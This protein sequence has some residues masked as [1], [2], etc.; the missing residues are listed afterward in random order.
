MPRN[1]GAN[2]SSNFLIVSWNVRSINARMNDLYSLISDFCPHIICMSEIMLDPSDIIKVNNYRAVI[3]PRNRR[4]GG[5]AI[6][7]RSDVSV[8]QVFMQDVFDLCRANEV[9]LVTVSCRVLGCT[10]F[11]ISSLYSP[12]RS[13]GGGTDLQ[14]WDSLFSSLYHRGRGL[15]T[16]DFNGHSGLWSLEGSRVNEEGRKIESAVTNA[17]YT[18]MN[19]GSPTWSSADSSSRSVLDL[20]FVCDSVATGFNFGVMPYNY[21]SD[22]FPIYLETDS[23]TPVVLPIRPTIK[24]K[25]VDWVLCN[26]VMQDKVCDLDFR[27]Q[28]GGRLYDGFVEAARGSLLVS[29]GRLLNRVKCNPHRRASPWWNENCMSLMKSKRD[30]YSEFATHPSLENFRN[31]QSVRNYIKKEIKKIRIDSFKKFCESLNMNTDTGKVWRT[32]RSFRDGKVSRPKLP[33]NTDRDNTLDLFHDLCRPNIIGSAG[34]GSPPAPGPSRLHSGYADL[35][36][37]LGSGYYPLPSG[38]GEASDGGDVGPSIGSVTS[39]VARANSVI[40][41]SLTEG[42]IRCSIRSI[43]ARS[44]HGPDLVGPDFVK[45][46]SPWMVE[47]LLRIFN[48]IFNHGSFP[49][50]WSNYF[51]IFIPKPGTNKFRPIALANTLFKVFEKIIFYRLN[52][53]CERV[54]V[55]PDFQLG[56]RRGRSVDDS[57]SVLSS[58]I[59]LAFKRGI[60]LGALFLDIKGA[61]DNV[62]PEI[63]RDI[64]GQVGLSP[65]L[66]RFIY[67]VTANRH[68]SGYM[69]GE[70][71]GEGTA[72]RGL[73]QGSSLSPL[74]Y[75]IY[76]AF[77]ARDLPDE[78]KVLYYADDI[79]VFVNSGSLRIIFDRLQEAFVHFHFV[80]KELQLELSCSKSKICIFGDRGRI[81]DRSCI[82]RNGLGVSFLGERVPVVESVCFLGVVFDRRLSWI[83]HAKSVGLRCGRRVNVMKSVAG[84]RWGAHPVTLLTIYRGWVRSLLDYGCV[85]FCDVGGDAACLMDRV[86]FRSLRIALSLFVTTPT[87]VI[88]HLAGEMPLSVRRRLLVS[89]RLIKLLGSSFDV[90]LIGRFISSPSYRRFIEDMKTD[91]FLLSAIEDLRNDFGQ[92][93][94][95]SGCS[96]FG[97]VS[98]FSSFFSIKIDIDSG[99]QIP[100]RGSGTGGAEREGVRMVDGDGILCGIL[101]RDGLSD[102]CIFYTDG[103]HMPNVGV[104]AGVFGCAGAIRLR[105]GLCKFLSIF[106]AEA[107]AILHALRNIEEGGMRKSVIISDSLSVLSSLKSFN[108]P[109]RSHPLIAAIKEI[110][111]SLY[112]NG[113]DVRLMWVPSHSGLLGNDEADAMARAGA[114]GEDLTFEHAKFCFPSNLFPVIQEEFIKFTLD[115]FR[116]EAIDKGFRYFN[117]V[118]F[119]KLEPWFQD[120]PGLSRSTITFLSRLRSHHV[121]LAYHLHEKGLKD[122]PRCICGAIETIQHF[123]VCPER[124]DHLLWLETELAKIDPSFRSDNIA[125][126]VFCDNRRVWSLLTKFKAKTGLRV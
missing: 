119:R 9:E 107:I 117:K 80:L 55:V 57:L 62:N 58:E 19:D 41:K 106:E 40:I 17:G 36:R 125:N 102:A 95:S 78:V 26:R 90:S 6:L 38:A 54:H 8:S 46:L 88:L 14:F 4:G 64:L 47:S 59:R 105:M 43:R 52:W 44:A 75:S 83:E 5:S 72:T 109:G 116:D 126:L 11:L 25:K 49:D 51:T 28:D 63:L 74:L 122:D 35:S 97:D 118:K 34:S 112:S 86:Q 111:W 60:R 77:L 110:I 7:C 12:P 115:K 66:I 22:H 10:D 124:G 61:F 85:A 56:F 13:S 93:L 3:C 20:F 31:F 67:F 84:L 1:Q 48:K 114:M 29:G 32:L 42:E 37:R 16:G 92:L 76:T 33:S 39:A 53:W 2:N 99:L 15:V 108:A 82:E 98:Y 21:G 100:R 73:P 120:H 87:N 113:F 81:R 123:F 103:S 96:A 69:G 30:A 68:L 18:C 70:C 23:F 79:V 94:A 50:S 91:N 24:T 121:N 27:S 101:E 89:R 104:G 71:L 45:N 65:K